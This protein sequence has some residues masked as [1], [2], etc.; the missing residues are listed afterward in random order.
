MSNQRIQLHRHTLGELLDVTRGT[1]LPGSN[2]ATSGKL[3]RL[4]LGNFDYGG[5]GFKENTSKENIYYTGNVPDEFIMEAGDIITPLTEQTPG[6]LGTTARIP[7]SRRYIQ[8]QDVALITCKPGKIDPL[9]CYY[10]VS[11]TIV[12]QQ[13]AAGSQQTKIRH[14]SPEKIKACVVYIPE[15]IT[16]QHRI[17]AFLS[18]IDEKISLNRKANTEMETLAKQIYDYWFVQFDFP[19]DNGRPYKSSGGRMAYDSTIKREIPE[20]WS[21]DRLGHIVAEAGTN[22]SVAQRGD[23]PYTPMD[24]LPIRKMSFSSSLPTEDAQSSLVKYS[25]HDI[26]IGAMR[27]YFHR[28]CIA[29]FDGIT[30]TTTLVLRPKQA[31]YYAYIYERLNADDFINYA[32]QMSNGS[33]QPMV[34]WSSLENMSILVPKKD[35]ALK[36]KDLFDGIRDKVISLNMENKRLSSMRDYLLPLLMNGQANLN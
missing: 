18:A 23:L 21:T 22:I 17:G 24:Q 14:T 8:S 19:D 26:L 29:P 6:L 1:S 33:Q 27:V 5:N 12:K 16:I 15:D 30:R 20:G 2:Y 3:I 31:D 10:L 9:F 11:S 28:V 35:I 36:Y 25:K 13:L 7:V 32:I 34:S 4:T